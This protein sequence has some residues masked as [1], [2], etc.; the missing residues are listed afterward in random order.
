MTVLL[1]LQIRNE[2]LASICSKDGSYS[3]P[4][5]TE[6][7]RQKQTVTERQTTD[8][9]GMAVMVQGDLS[10]KMRCLLDA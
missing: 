2:C 7:H 5:T 1:S 6:A 8:K 3:R 10:I 4:L 9:H